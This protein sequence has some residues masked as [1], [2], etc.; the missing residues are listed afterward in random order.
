LRIFDP[1]GHLAATGALIAGGSGLT[2]LVLTG[3]KGLAK[4]ALSVST[5]TVGTASAPIFATLENVASVVLMGLAYELCRVNPWLIVVLLAVVTVAV[6]ALVVFALYQLRRLKKGIGRVLYLA[7][8]H[9]RAGLAVALEFLVWGSGWL[10]WQVWGRGLLMLAVW[11]VWL[12]I[13]ITVPAAVGGLFMVFPPVSP[14]AAGF[15]A[16]VLLGVFLS[17]GVSSARALLKQLEKEPVPVK[18]RRAEQTA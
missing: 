10:I 18:P 6:G 16:L 2:A 5:G 9:P 1:Q 7:Q 4:P 17:V 14:V 13:F 12:G 11:A 3:S 8:V 15:S